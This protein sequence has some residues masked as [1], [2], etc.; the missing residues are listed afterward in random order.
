MDRKAAHGQVI[1]LPVDK[2]LPA[3]IWLFIFPRK[4]L[5]GT[6]QTSKEWG[7]LP[8][9]ETCCIKVN[10]IFFKFVKKNYSKLIFSF[11]LPHSPIRIFLIYA[12][13]LGWRVI[14][15][16]ALYLFFLA[17]SFSPFSC[18]LGTEQVQTGTVRKQVHVSV[19]FHWGSCVKLS[20]L[21]LFD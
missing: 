1:C 18:L 2:V 10:T 17:A 9:K 8:I 13:L 6:Q 3:L 19:A 4:S 7:S 20:T 16:T 11:S 21:E 15:S 14:S 5:N 12:A